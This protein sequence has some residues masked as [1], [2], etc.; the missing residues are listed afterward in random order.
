MKKLLIILISILFLA[1]IA[2]KLSNYYISKLED[3]INTRISLLP[4]PDHNNKTNDKNLI[5]YMEFLA[6]KTLEQHFA[7]RGNQKLLELIK[8]RQREVHKNNLK[9]NLNNK[10]YMQFK[11]H[12]QEF[13]W[14]KAEICTNTFPLENLPQDNRSIISFIKF[15]K[16]NILPPVV[17]RSA[18]AYAYD[19]GSLIAISNKDRQT[20]VTVTEMRVLD[21][22]KIKNVLYF[23]RKL[24]L[25]AFILL[26]VIILITFSSH[27]KKFVKGAD[28]SMW[29]MFI[30]PVFSLYAGCVG[31]HSYGWYDFLRIV[32][33]LQAAVFAFL[34]YQSQYK[35]SAFLFTA[36]ALLF[37]PI[38]KVRL[39]RSEWEPLDV[40]VG[41]IFILTNI[42]LIK[43]KQQKKLVH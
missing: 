12:A 28:P 31:F 11:S 37:N 14:H 41:I 17:A 16:I 19:D 23:Q 36:I 1:F 32:V 2:N 15:E 29:L 8:Y 30:V 10:G 33:T 24:P 9:D 4:K 27:I 20:L 39:S 5:D 35:A 43:Q 42:W 38:I 26:T 6:P 40:M 3:D 34:F 18:I 25:I 22:E 13:D 21:E 7:A